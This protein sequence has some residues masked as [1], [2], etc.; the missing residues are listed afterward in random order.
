ML[1]RLFIGLHFAVEIHHF[2]RPRLIPH[3]ITLILDK[4]KLRSKMVAELHVKR[5]RASINCLRENS[6]TIELGVTINLTEHVD[7]EIAQAC[8]CV[9]Y[10]CSTE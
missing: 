2:D 1:A 10:T 8:N 4:T 7:I 3:L 6:D 9:G 5:I